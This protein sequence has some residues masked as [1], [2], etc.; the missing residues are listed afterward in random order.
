MKRSGRRPSIHSVLSKQASMKT[1]A[2]SGL[3]N[4]RQISRH[5]VKPPKDL[6]GFWTCNEERGTRGPGRCASRSPRGEDNDWHL[7]CD[8][9]GSRRV[10]SGLKLKRRKVTWT[11]VTETEAF[12]IR[13]QR[14]CSVGRAVVAAQRLQ[15]VH[16][17]CR[18]NVYFYVY[19]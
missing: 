3:F 10:C 8:V 4:L 6:A 15:N 9:F 11:G 7:Q 2:P 17:T 5:S 16:C 1:A 12:I 14:R 13:G 19:I 18:L